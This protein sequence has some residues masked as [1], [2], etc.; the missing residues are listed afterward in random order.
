V[1]DGR[2]ES[3]SLRHVG[4]GGDRIVLAYARNKAAD[5]QPLLAEIKSQSGAEYCAIVAP[6]GEYFAHSNPELKGKPAT[7]AG[8]MTEQWGDVSRV[9]YANDSGVSIHEYRCPLKSGDK[10]LGMLWL[11]IAQRNVWS[12]IR[13]SAEFAP[14]AFFGPACCLIAGALLLNRMVRP[15]ADIEQ[16][17]LR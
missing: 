17:Q 2:S 8:A 14:L 3:A 11:G 7:E 16:Q 13:E 10:P 4:R 6:T 1:T 12:F 15:V 9:E 5:L